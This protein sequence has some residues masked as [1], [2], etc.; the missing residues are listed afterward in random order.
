[1]SKLVLTN[2]TYPKIQEYVRRIDAEIGM[3]GYV[4]LIDGDFYVDDVFL[5]EQEVTG[6]SVDFTDK[7]LDYAINKAIEDGRIEDLKFCCHSHVNMDAFWSGTDEDMIKS[8]NNGM[9]PYL[10]SLVINKRHETEQRV[11]FYNPAGPIGEFTGQITFNLDLEVETSDSPE[12]DEEINKLVSRKSFNRGWRGTQRNNYGHW[13]T[14]TERKNEQKLLPVAN[15]AGDIERYV[16]EN[17][18]NELSREEL[19]A[20]GMSELDIQAWFGQEVDPW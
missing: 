12:I 2:N 4:T 14:E 5:V 13:F 17:D 1:M 19:R 6:G 9:T 7:G 3:F 11:D 8:M 16:D 10:V 20:L 18:A 15:S